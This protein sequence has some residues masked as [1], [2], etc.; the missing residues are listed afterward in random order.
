MSQRLVLDDVPSDLLARLNEYAERLG[1]SAAEAASRILSQTLSPAPAVPSNDTISPSL[2]RRG[3][4]LVHTGV[5]TA[6]AQWPDASEEREEWANE[7]VKRS[8]E[9]GV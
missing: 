6:G 9:G 7:L 8:L 4:L 2:V 3:R 1:I 5:L